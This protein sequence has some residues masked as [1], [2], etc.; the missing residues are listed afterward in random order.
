MRTKRNTWW[1]LACVLTHHN[2]G[3]FHA[4]S[5]PYQGQLSAL[6]ITEPSLLGRQALA[7]RAEGP[8]SPAAR[9]FISHALAAIT[10]RQDAR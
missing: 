9:A 5:A 4:S 1:V 8:I 6:A 2:F 7:W 3:R 10:D